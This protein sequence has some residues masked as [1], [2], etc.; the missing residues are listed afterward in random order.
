MEYPASR[1]SVLIGP[2]N[3]IKH[4]VTKERLP[5]T[6]AYFGSLAVTLYFSLGV[7]VACITLLWFILNAALHIGTLLYWFS[8]RCY[9]PGVLWMFLFHI[10]VY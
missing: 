6:F 8:D 1:F 5:F 10:V 2:L 3:H 4:L 9:N 7:R